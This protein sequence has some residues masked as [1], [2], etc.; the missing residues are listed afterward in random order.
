MESTTQTLESF[1]SLQ[2]ETRE[3]PFILLV[4]IRDA[5]CVMKWMSNGDTVEMLV[6]AIQRLFMDTGYMQ[7]I[8][9]SGLL[10]MNCCRCEY[11]NQCISKSFAHFCASLQLACLSVPLFSSATLPWSV[12]THHLYSFSLA[13]NNHASRQCDNYQNIYTIKSQI[14]LNP[15]A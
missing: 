4:F 9:C 14:V 13:A 1:Q 7:L 5:F 10:G 2:L 12:F 15:V 6:L 3:I 8:E 11:I